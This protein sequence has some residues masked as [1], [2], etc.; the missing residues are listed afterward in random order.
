MEQLERCYGV[1]GRETVFFY[2]LNTAYKMTNID[3]AKGRHGF[4]LPHMNVHVPPAH[5][6][7]LLLL[8]RVATQVSLI[9][10]F[11]A[12]CRQ[13]STQIQEVNISTKYKLKIEDQETL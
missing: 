10:R 4:L 5:Q 1:C 3:I 11:W 2:H 8:I 9:P 6:L 12:T 7:L 13:R